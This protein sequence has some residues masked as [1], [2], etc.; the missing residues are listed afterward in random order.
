MTRTE[1]MWVWIGGLLVG[2]AAIGGVAYAASTKPSAVP[3]A[4]TPA[5]APAPS[6]APTPTPAPV[7]SIVLA[8]GITQPV[9]VVTG[10]T[11]TIGLPM[12]AVW[13]S[14]TS[15]QG[16]PFTVSDAT[17]LTLTINTTGTIAAVYRD[18]YGVLQNAG[19]AVTAT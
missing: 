6:P 14:A 4:P 13:V 9:N 15:P 17:P 3:P 12:G 1:K 8:P 10:S 2:S 5:P 19:I 11:L 16:N 18:A 7:G